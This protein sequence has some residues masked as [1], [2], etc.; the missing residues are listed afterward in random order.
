MTVGVFAED[1]K[2]GFNAY[3]VGLGRVKC[4]NSYMVRQRTTRKVGDYRSRLMTTNV[5][6]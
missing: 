6:V 4:C 2:V 3:R 1:H 5:I